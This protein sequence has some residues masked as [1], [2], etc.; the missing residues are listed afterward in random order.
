MI[1]R[2]SAGDGAR[3]RAIRLRALSDSPDSFATTFEEAAAR[4]LESWERQLDEIA[5]FVAVAGANDVGLVRGTLHDQRKD[6]GYLISLWVVPEARGQGI[7][8]GLV[9]AVVAWARERRLVRLVLDV[10]EHNARALAL[11]TR[12]GFLPNGT[13]ST[14]PPPRDPSREIQLAMEL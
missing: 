4:S 9:S 10:G 12:M 1:V 7:G 6:T 13:T 8:A 5:T 11:Y 3:L 14:L 2:L